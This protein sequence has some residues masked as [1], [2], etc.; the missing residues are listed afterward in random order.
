[1]HCD[2]CRHK[3]MRI[4]AEAYGVISV[5]LDD[6]KEKLVVV[7]DGVDTTCLTTMLRKK[8]GYT[9]LVTI[10]EDKIEE[11]KKPADKKKCPHHPCCAC[12]CAIVCPPGCCCIICVDKKE[13]KCSPP[14]PPPSDCP[15]NRCPPGY[16]FYQVQV[17][18]NE[19]NPTPCS[20]M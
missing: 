3:A 17:T 14:P 16:C 18:V 4:A 8:V 20:I 15:C 2:D 7:G 10:E 1:M 11:V 12:T 13:K 9:V 19:I 5:S 6:S